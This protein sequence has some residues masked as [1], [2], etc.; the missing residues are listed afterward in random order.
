MGLEESIAVMT[1]A[2]RLN[3]M[4]LFRVCVDYASSSATPETCCLLLGPAQM[5]GLTDVEE[6]CLGSAELHFDTVSQSASFCAL[7]ADNLATL[8]SRETLNTTELSVFRAAMA[9]VEHDLEGRRQHVD[10]LLEQVRLPLISAE[11]LATLDK[12]PAVGGNRVFLELLLEAFKYH[13][14][15]SSVDTSP[16]RFRYRVGGHFTNM[17]FGAQGLTRRIETYNVPSSGYYRVSAKGASGS[18]SGGCL[19]GKGAIVA[20]TVILQKDDVLHIVIG[21]CPSSRKHPCGGGGTWVTRN[22]LENRNVLLV[23]GGGGGASPMAD[24]PS[25]RDASV[26]ECGNDG[27]P[28]HAGGE[29]HGGKHGLAGQ[30]LSVANVHYGR[31]GVGIVEGCFYHPHSD[32]RGGG[33]TGTS[34]GGGGG[35]GYSGGGGGLAGGGGGSFVHKSAFNVDR[36]VGHCGDGTVSIT[37]LL[38][39][40]PDTDSV[41]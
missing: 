17:H 19:G 7:S 14:N 20:G 12:S 5:F 8:L 3:E 24:G 25:G 15:A 10:R 1:V 36:A 26:D 13:A 11:E 23:A 2:H 39:A 32:V 29:S 37:R 40:N 4:D 22:G 30:N 21:E 18:D 41:A 6:S 38:R 33:G 28:A 35:G 34:H 31:G 9:W 16:T 27:V